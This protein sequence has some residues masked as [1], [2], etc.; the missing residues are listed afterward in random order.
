MAEK[1]AKSVNPE[2]WKYFSGYPDLRK[3]MHGKV[4]NKAGL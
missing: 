3:L 2:T 1:L 4:E